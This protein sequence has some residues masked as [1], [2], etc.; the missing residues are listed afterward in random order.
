MNKA[1]VKDY[2][3]K[4][5]SILPK[6]LT[7]HIDIKRRNKYWKS[8]GMVFVHVP[9][10]A[11]VSIS[12]ALYG[13][14]LGH[15][16]ASDIRKT[17]KHTFEHSFSFGISRHPLDR[18]YSA[19]RFALSGGEEMSF[20]GDNRLIKKLTFEEF[21]FEWLVFQDLSCI[22]GIFRPQHLYLCESNE[23]IVKKV[24][25]FDEIDSMQ[26]FLSSVVGRNIIIPYANKTK[27][28]KDIFVNHSRPLLQTIEE[29]YAKDFE[30]FGY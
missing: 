12:K 21:I 25:K 27:R 7:T 17:L 8:Q 13:R 14:P 4:G 5:Y 9:K 24:F 19:Y 16:Y 22:D 11:G 2:F 28:S 29:M 30:V 23:I 18:I 3:Y 26:E 6:K 1:K 10:N 20:G 15:F